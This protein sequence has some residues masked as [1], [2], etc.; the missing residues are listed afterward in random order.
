[1]TGASLI[2]VLKVIYIAGCHRLPNKRGCIVDSVHVNCKA[3]CS[4]KR[5]NIF[6]KVAIGW[7]LGVPN[8]VQASENIFSSI[9]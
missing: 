5:A 9:F 4:V 3:F 2:R 7:L 8:I 1:V 6:P